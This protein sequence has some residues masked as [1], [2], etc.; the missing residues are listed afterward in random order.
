[1]SAAVDS[2]T[3]TPIILDQV[4]SFAELAWNIATFGSSNAATKAVTTTKNLIK[5]TAVA[6]KLTSLKA[7][8]KN[9]EK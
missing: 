3:C 1:M 4:T 9:N 2:K 8:V 6:K 5:D 7:T